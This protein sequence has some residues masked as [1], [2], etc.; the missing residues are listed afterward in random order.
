MSITSS[1]DISQIS[2]IR[3]AIERFIVVSRAKHAARVEQARLIAELSVYR[4]VTDRADMDAILSRYPDSE[5]HHAW[6]SLAYTRS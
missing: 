5:T 2:P 3:A 4:S 1:I 6:S